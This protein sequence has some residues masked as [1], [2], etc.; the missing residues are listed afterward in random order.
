[1]TTQINQVEQKHVFLDENGQPIEVR[2]ST[3]TK[4]YE[5]KKTSMWTRLKN[6]LG[7]IYLPEILSAVCEEETMDDKLKMIRAWWVRDPK[8]AELMRTFILATYHPGVKFAFPKCK[9]PFHYNDCTDFGMAP[10]TLFKA[11]RKLKLLSDG[12][13]KITNVTK[14]ENM[15]IQQLETL[16]KVE[17]D[18]YLM[19]V[20]KE[21][22]QE[23]YPGIDEDFLRTAFSAVLP[24]KK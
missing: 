9:P 15:L 16:Y 18:L 24:P 23:V 21:I 20:F 4:N 5:A 7:T 10:N 22:D 12:P 14:R 11:V 2:P 1:M 19:M 17:A 3:R 13:D 6:P 8:N